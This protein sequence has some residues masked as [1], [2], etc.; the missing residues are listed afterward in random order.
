MTREERTTYWKKLVDQ[1]TDS[2]LTGG[3]FCREQNINPQRFYH[4]RRRFKENE[5]GAM[6]SG[7]FELV[8]CSP[9][10]RGSG[11][12]IHL[13]HELHIEIDRGFDP[14]TLRTVIETIGA[15]KPCLP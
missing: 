10:S 4:W 2:G 3:A 11:I 9:Q 15:G 6:S 7:F 14:F 1:Q 8:P 5:P 12:Y 13:S